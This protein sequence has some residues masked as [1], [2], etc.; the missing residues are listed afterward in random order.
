VVLVVY[1]ENFENLSLSSISVNCLYETDREK[2]VF[3]P[4]RMMIKFV[5]KVY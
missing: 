3:D 2:L 1:N 4:A 5:S